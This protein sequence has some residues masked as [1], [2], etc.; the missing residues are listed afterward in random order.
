MNRI[1]IVTVVGSDANETLQ[2]FGFATKKS[3]PALPLPALATGE[4]WQWNLLDLG[5]PIRF[6]AMKSTRE[7]TRHR[8]KYAEGQLAP[9]KSFYFRGP[10]GN[11]NL[12]AQNWI[13]FCQ[14]AD[15]IDDE[16]WLY[17]LKRNDFACWFRDCINDEDLASE[18]E[19]AAKD[20]N[21]TAKESKAQ[22]AVAIQ[23]NYILLSS[24]RISVPGAM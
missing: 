7:H 6:M 1:A 15:G 17:H 12:R 21:S 14:L 3:V 23:R 22:I 11:L 24:S 2:A 16:T 19:L 20:S 4:V 18:A 13:L 5:S 8:R 9:E 10:E